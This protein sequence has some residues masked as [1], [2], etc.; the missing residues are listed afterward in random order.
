M[1]ANG[2]S[3]GSSDS[4]PGA[5]PDDHDVMAP[6]TPLLRPD[7]EEPP[8]RSGPARTARDGCW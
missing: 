8:T 7:G 5:A 4:E 2:S 6:P 3:G 1:E